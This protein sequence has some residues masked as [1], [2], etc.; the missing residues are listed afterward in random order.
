MWF[1]YLIPTD[2]REQAIII[3]GLRLWIIALEERGLITGYAF[4]HYHDNPP[5]LDELRIR[6]EYANEDSIT[7]VES[8]LQ[9][10][11]EKFIPD[12]KLV[13]RSW[14]KECPESNRRAYE[15]GSRCAFLLWD[16]IEKGRIKQSWV[17]DFWPVL[18]EKKLVPLDF[19]QSVNHALWNS[20]SVPKKPNE[21]FIH[22]F[23]FIQLAELHNM[24]ELKE[25]IGNLK[26]LC[27]WCLNK[28]P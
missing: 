10:E 17:S 24:D 8:E 19:Q 12:F 4:N 15:F 16:L 7:Y 27:E 2:A 1:E 13:K 21:L 6:F 14:N 26:E 11:V 28:T 20:L 23:L 22:L 25:W 5:N 9:I 18:T 3:R